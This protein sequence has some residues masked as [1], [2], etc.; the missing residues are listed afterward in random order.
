MSLQI[1][2]HRYFARLSGGAQ[3]LADL[4]MHAKAQLVVKEEIA[5]LIRQHARP[6]AALLDVGGA[7]GHATAIYRDQLVDP[8]R[9]VI[10]DWKDYRE[11]D[12]T[13]ALEF[14]QVNLEIDRFP[15]DDESFDVVVCNQVFEHL[16]NIYTPISEVHRVL[17][18]SGYLILSVP[19]LAAMHN[20][21]LLGIG[22]QPSTIRLNGS[23]VRGLAAREMATWLSHGDL[24]AIVE[25]VAVGMPPF[26]S[27]RLPAR[28]TNICH[29]PIW[30]L[31]KQQG[32]AEDWEGARMSRFTSTNFFGGS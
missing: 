17:K 24:F 7:S 26:T 23:H 29:S 27:A 6:G 1:E 21:V 15:D 22:R 16:K 20:R 10:Y 11:P 28:L 31:R 13:D 14:E 25:A 12:V 3:R 9:V 18:P 2:Q 19:N 4:P 8:E 30:L 5:R 32:D